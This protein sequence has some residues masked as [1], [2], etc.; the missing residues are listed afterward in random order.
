VELGVG[1]TVFSVVLTIFYALSG[2]RRTP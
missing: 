2:R 1:L